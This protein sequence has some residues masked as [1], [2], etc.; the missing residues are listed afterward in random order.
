MDG[1]D[2]NQNSGMALRGASTSA[3]TEA[4]GEQLLPHVLRFFK[5]TLLYL[6]R[7]REEADDKEATRYQAIETNVTVTV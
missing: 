3:L 7:R 6:E 4:A 1:T 5:S 2:T